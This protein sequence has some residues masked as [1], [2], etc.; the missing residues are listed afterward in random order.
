MIRITIESTGKSHLK[1]KTASLFETTHETVL[2]IKE[3]REFLIDRYGK[4]P[5]GRNKIYVDDKDGNTKVL[6]F[7][8]SFWNNDISHVP[9]VSWYQ[10]DWITAVYV[11]ET[12]VNILGKAQ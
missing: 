2:D 4:L 7:T 3:A 6:G 5:G 1:Q 9:V 8:Y 10:T 12:P 11:V